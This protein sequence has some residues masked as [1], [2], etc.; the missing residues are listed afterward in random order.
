[1]PT[2]HL[3]VSLV[4]LVVL[5]SRVADVDNTVEASGFLW[6]ALCHIDLAFQSVSRPALI[7]P[8]CV[9]VDAGV[10]AWCGH[11]F[12][13]EFEVSEWFFAGFIEQV[14]AFAVTDEMTIFNLP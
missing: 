10:A 14:T 11:H 12:A 9:E 6:V 1:V 4:P 3:D 8:L 7:L 2:L 5:E 13:F